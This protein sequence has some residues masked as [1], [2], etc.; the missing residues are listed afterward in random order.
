MLLVV[1]LMLAGLVVSLATRSTQ[2][3]PGADLQT[4][5]WDSYKAHYWHDSGQ[6]TDPANHN[7]TTSEAQSYTMLRAVWQ[8]DPS[9]FTATWRWTADHL[10]RNDKLFSWLYG[11]SGVVTAQNGQN[12]ASDADI[13]IALALVLASG[14]WH[15]EDYLRSAT[16]IIPA[17]WN[18]EVITVQSKPYLTADNLEKR[19]DTPLLNPSYFSPAAYRIFASIDPDHAWIEL[20]DQSYATLQAASQSRLGSPASANLPPDWVAINRQTGKLQAPASSA[21]DT[22]FGFDAF[23]TIWQSALDWQW[24]QPAAAK[25]TL[26]SF[27]SLIDHWNHQHKLYAIYT[28]D[29]KPAVNYS[30]IALY[31]GTLGY[32]SVV[33]PA[34]ATQIYEQQLAPLLNPKTRQL[35]STLNYYDNSWAWFGTALYQNQLHKYLPPGVRL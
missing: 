25:N 30:S 9:V 20:A 7:F 26:A 14:R 35:K 5:L 31:G 21:H 12:T 13:N 17:I 29:G 8:N 2:T 19:S 1:L 6:T 18:E 32:F 16:A 22:N 28:H 34:V 3:T 27:S 24:D 15:N 4:A 23:R 33:H 11:P 10:Q